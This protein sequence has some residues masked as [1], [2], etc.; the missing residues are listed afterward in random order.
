MSA[1]EPWFDDLIGELKKPVTEN[2]QAKAKIMEKVRAMPSQRPTRR[3]E[4]LLTFLEWLVRRRAV[5]VS[6]LAVG[7][8]ALIVIAG[9]IA[10]GR[11]T[12]RPHGPFRGSA[13]SKYGTHVIGE[14]EAVRLAHAMKPGESLVN[15][16]LIAPGASRVAV[17]G[18]FNNWEAGATP[19][20]QESESGLWTVIVPLSA[21]RHEYAFLVDGES[22]LPDPS[23]PRAPKDDFDRVNSIM[24]I[25]G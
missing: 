5:A 21:G 13:L 10:T 16:V 4:A 17:I 12:T 2:A 8:C 6:P 18:D 3:G 19:L 1:N 22:W 14:N 7:V 9:T 23:A 11:L 25:E 24:L 15:F 20:Q